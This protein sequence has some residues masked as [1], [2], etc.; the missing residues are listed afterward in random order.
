MQ[1][2]GWRP[3][4]LRERPVRRPCASPAIEARGACFFNDLVRLLQG[5]G[6]FLKS[7]IEEALWE[8]ASAGMVTADGFDNLRALFTPNAAAPR[9]APVPPAPATAPAA[10]RW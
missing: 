7:Q 5:E 8:L 2:A 3:E 4:E 6:A 10:G 1:V 9:D